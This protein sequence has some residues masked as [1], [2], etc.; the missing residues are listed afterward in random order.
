M[1][2][3]RKKI[4]QLKRVQKEINNVT[5][6]V[7][8]AIAIGL[9]EEHGWTPDMISDLFAYTQELWGACATKDIS[10]IK[11]CEEITGIEMQAFVAEKAKAGE[12]S[13][14]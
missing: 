13:E 9:Y 6:S 7:Y 3:D 1:K 8:A 11:W 10:M 5:P 12:R 2:I 4:E 14:T